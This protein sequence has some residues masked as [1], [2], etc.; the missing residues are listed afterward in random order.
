MRDKNNMVNSIEDLNYPKG[1]AIENYEKFQDEEKP[2]HKG[3][4]QEEAVKINE[5]ADAIKN[6]DGFNDALEKEVPEA[7]ESFLNDVKNNR[8]KYENYDKRWIDH[9]EREVIKKYKKGE[10]WGAA[11]NVISNSI[12]ENNKAPRMEQLEKEAIN[13]YVK[14]SEWWKA[15]TI[16]ENMFIPE[17]PND[18][19]AEDK[20]RKNKVNRINQLVIDSSTEY[21][22][23]KE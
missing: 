18:P 16:I 17:D 15:K 3:R 8:D 20:A 12:I 4:L 14:K 21:D 6:T 10:N 23:I 13:A 2:K 7:A 22:D 5:M 11:K 9:R 19:T 1:E